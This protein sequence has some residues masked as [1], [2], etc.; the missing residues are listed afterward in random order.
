MVLR[1]PFPRLHSPSVDDN[2]YV[3]VQVETST[4]QHLPT[5]KPVAR[6]MVSKNRTD[7]P[8]PGSAANSVAADLCDPSSR[9]FMTQDP[10]ESPAGSLR[11]SLN[12]NQVNKDSDGFSAR[13]ELRNSVKQTVKRL[14]TNWDY[15]IVSTRRISN[16]IVRMT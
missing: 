5:I 2:H 14:E 8:S 3:S 7:P 10:S 16:R 4:N 13:C 11:I 12:G 15:R 6:Q 9:S 1:C